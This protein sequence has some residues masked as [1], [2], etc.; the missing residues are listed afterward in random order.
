MS[1]HDTPCI[2]WFD[3]R[4]PAKDAARLAWGFHSADVPFGWMELLLQTMRQLVQVRTSARELSLSLL[5][6]SVDGERLEVDIPWGDAVLQGIARRCEERSR[7]ICRQCGKRGLLRRFGMHDA[8]VLCARCAAPELLHSAIDDATRYPGLMAIGGRVDDLR[9]VPEVLRKTFI[10][11]ARSGCVVDAAAE[12][13]MDA[14][15][16][17]RW[18]AHLQRLQTRLPPPTCLRASK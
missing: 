9:R 18:V 6:V 5:T 14:A 15:D 13:H 3:S 1:Q 2:R 8:A 10:Q 12:P 4:K 11:A 7:F 16:F 17:R